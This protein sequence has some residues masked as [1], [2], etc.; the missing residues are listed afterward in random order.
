MESLGPLSP[1]P[2]SPRTRAVP[3]IVTAVLVVAS[4]AGYAVTLHATRDSR[5]QSARLAATAVAAD[6]QA[7][8]DADG[9]VLQIG[10]LAL[11]GNAARSVDNVRAVLTPYVDTASLD[12]I[13]LATPAAD[14]SVRIDPD[15]VSRFAALVPGGVLTRSPS[16]QLALDVARDD[17][18]VRAA[19]TPGRSSA[20]ILE[21]APVFAGSVDPATS[22]DP[23]AVRRQELAGYLVMIQSADD[24]AGGSFQAIG[25]IAARIVEGASPLASN[26]PGSHSAPSSAASAPISANGLSWSV[27]TWPANSRSALPVGVLLVGLVIASIVGLVSR[28]TTRASRELARVALE[29]A[30]ELRLVARTSPLLQ[31]SLELAELLPQFVVEVSDVLDLDA[32]AISVVSSRGELVRAFAFGSAIPEPATGMA[33]LRP[34]PDFVAPGDVVTVPLQRGGRVIGALRARARVGLGPARVETLRAVSDL[35]ASAIGNARLFQQEQEMVTRLRELDRMK[36]VFLG[37]VSHELRTTVTAIAGFASL[38]AAQSP[39][40][41]PERRGDY[42]ERISRNAASLGVLVEDLLD[43]SRI[44]RASLSVSPQPVNLSDIIPNLGAQVSSLL[45]D[46]EVSYDIEPN[47]I[48]IADP[49]AVERIMSNLLS[50]VAKYTPARTQAKVTVRYEGDRA[51]IYVDDSGPG[52]P[53]AERDRIFELFY[54]VDGPST[55]AARGIGIGLALVA[56]LVS[57]LNGTVV[58]DQAPG[59]GAR[60]RVEFPASDTDPAEPSSVDAAPAT[61]N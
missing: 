6:I 45:E 36:T 61:P 34:V 55:R 4:V 15:D 54:R 44:E 40:A 51:V 21:A 5:R 16:W 13:T 22:G 48:A 59:G 28:R 46:H 56:Q 60:F 9:T 17:G 41:N 58:A 38:L 24:V 32:M 27:Q 19:T 50:N 23:V 49:I 7:R 3:A 53:V 37:S 14:G 30:E 33:E 10:A 12:H 2:L 39:N 20:T 8:L 1:G 29:G 52:I 25:S 18:R 57:L 43:F 35:L 11:G 42:V 47:V 31:Q 26:G